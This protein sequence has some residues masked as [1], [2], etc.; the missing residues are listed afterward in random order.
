MGDWKPGD[1]AMVAGGDGVER[2]AV[3]SGHVSRGPG[4]VIPF[5]GHWD[6]HYDY[7]VTARPLILIDPEDRLQVGRLCDALT[8]NRAMPLPDRLALF[9]RLAENADRMQAALREFANPTP[10]KPE[11]PTGL[12]AVVEDLGDEWVH[13]G[14][15]C[16]IKT[17]PN[18]QLRQTTWGEFSDAVKILSPG[19][20][21]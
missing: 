19:V 20:T 17:V 6:Q 8:G 18:A 13:F 16:W 1:V 5:E 14:N 3:W 15:G 2:L 7:Q 4:W 12:G 21:P 11:E 10:P 9:D